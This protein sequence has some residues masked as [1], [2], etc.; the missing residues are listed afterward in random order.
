M[1]PA[2][3]TAVQVLTCSFGGRRH[4]VRRALAALPEEE[5]LR[6]LHQ[7][8]LT[9]RRRQIEAV[10]L[11]D[12]LRELDPLP[13][14]IL[15]DA[16]EDP[17]PELVLERLVE[18]GGELLPQLRALDH[19]RHGLKDMASFADGGDEDDPTGASEET[20]RHAAQAARRQ[21]Q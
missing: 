15:G 6:L 18:H 17:L 7:Q 1:S 5:L 8:L 12:H 14:R 4:V 13:P 3:R 9:L 20:E 19:P 11:D 2:P 10:L 21:A 16:V